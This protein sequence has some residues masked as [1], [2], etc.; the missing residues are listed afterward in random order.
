MVG[1]VVRDVEALRLAARIEELDFENEFF[2]DVD[3]DLLYYYTNTTLS[4]TDTWDATQLKEYLVLNA[5][6]D[7]PITNVVIRGLTVR[8]GG[9]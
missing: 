4:P 7:K 3:G 5:T 9:G 8:R 2:H 1:P 6:M